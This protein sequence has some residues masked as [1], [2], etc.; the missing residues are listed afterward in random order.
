MA[1]VV[2]FSYA[3][4]DADTTKAIASGLQQLG[5]T[6]WL[7]QQLSGGQQWWDTILEQIR[8]CDVFLFVLSKSSLRS[9]ACRA[10]LDYAHRLGRTLLPVS[11]DHVIDQL[12]PPYLAETQRVDGADLVQ[13]ARALLGLPSPPPLPEPLPPPP[14][15]PLSYLDELA[16]SLNREDL[17][18]AD[19]RNLLGALKQLVTEDDE[20]EAAVELL[21]RLRRH[22][23]VNAWVAEETDAELAKLEPVAATAARPA[24][25]LVG[26]PT[27]VDPAEQTAS[28]PEAS[29]ATGHRSVTGPPSDGGAGSTTRPRPQRRRPLVPP[30]PVKRRKG[31]A[32]LLAA[33]LGVALAGA[34]AAASLAG[35]SDDSPDP[36][37]TTD[38]SGVPTPTEP[39]PTEPP[40]TE[41]PPTEPPPTEPEP[42]LDAL[43]EDCAAA[44]MVACDDLFAESEVGSDDEAFGS[45]CGGFS[46]VPLEGACKSTFG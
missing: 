21:R 37:P 23:Q 2:F 41:P 9:K 6:V 7:D 46:A 15:V 26:A 18:L 40:I 16:D 33:L 11:V 30:P 1:H 31:R 28:L 34:G 27:P 43:R 5:Q 25:A 45:F 17:P 19:Q 42:D 20:R 4:H 36:P 29:P 38:D 44:D 8:N 32:V 13:L 39:P 35:G 10:E 12:M 3:R 24:T 22:P 14:S